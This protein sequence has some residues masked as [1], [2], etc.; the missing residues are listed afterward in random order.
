M[1]EAFLKAYERELSL[2]Y[3]RGRAF[4]DEHPGIASRLGGMT[5]GNLDP[6]VDGLFQGTAF[7]AA[8]VQLEIERQ[9][10]TFTSQL[11]DQ[12]LPN[13]LAPT[14]AAMMVQADPD[15]TDPEL[16]KGRKFPAGSYLDARYVEREQRVQCR[17][18]IAGALE[19]WPIKLTA[20]KYLTGPGP[21]QALDL[22]TEEDTSAGLQIVLE[23]QRPKGADKPIVPLSDVDLD[24]LPI[25]LT[26]SFGDAVEIYE[27]IFAQTLRVTLRY[28]DSRGDPVFHRLRPDQIKPVGL[29][30]DDSFFVEDTR[31]FHGFLLLREFFMFPQRFLGFRLTGLR[32]ALK[33]IES[34]EVQVLFE[35]SRAN[36]KLAPRVGE[37]D[38]GLYC[39]PAVNLFEEQASQ[40]KLEPRHSEYMVVAA[41]S[42]S[43]HYEVHRVTQVDALFGGGGPKIPV[44]PIYGAPPEMERPSQGLYFSTRLRQRL[45]SQTERRRMNSKDYRG[46]E[47]LLT[48]TEPAGLDSDDRAERLQI[49]T[50][51]SNRHLVQH[52]P[53]NQAGADFFL[54]N[55]VTVN[56]RCI[57]GPTTP[58]ES[59]AESPRSAGSQEG[60]GIVPWR[61]IS[62]LSLGFL[63][64][65]DRTDTGSARG[66][67]ELLSIFA[68]LGSAVIE[69]QIQG[70]TSLETRPI[71]RSIRRGGRYHTARGLE[72][73][74]TFDERAFDSS[75]ILLY[76]AVLERF[77]AEYAPINSFT[78]TVVMSK[79]RGQVK[80]FPTRDG[81]GEAL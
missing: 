20:A 3:E 70:I 67:R 53:I 55:D 50:I 60:T 24:E 35:F 54:T 9:F 7:L 75:G 13:L 79:Q 23:R 44:H 71:V 65:D 78:Q 6:A 36:Q 2:L 26:G 43:H 15:F 29:D 33:K 80:V 62:F 32:Q 40:I 22:E 14:P 72:V 12:L 31:V 21:L 19:L 58:R 34:Q 49:R 64:L 51:C 30:P 45:M 46:T 59:P 56:L 76:G 47:T 27:A 10:A 69:Q 16:A 8:R 18:R 68:D 39:V 1:N 37:D 52:L 11:L 4:A 5:E 25:W 38:F 42:P 28:T 17:F 57:A 73:R 48:F 77:F 41:S 74:V 63:G 81:K 61:L 66:L